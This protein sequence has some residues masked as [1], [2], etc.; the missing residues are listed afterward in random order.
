MRA[1]SAELMNGRKG[2]NRCVVAYGDMTRQGRR[3]CHD[4]MAADI[5]V[6]GDMDI[7]HK[8]VA[9]SDYGDPIA[10][11]RGAVNGRIFPYDVP[12]P[13]FHPCLFIAVL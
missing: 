2:A 5:R 11:N 9:F 12:V 4:D 3:I 7:G 1:D 6:V 13:Y 10:T 8:E